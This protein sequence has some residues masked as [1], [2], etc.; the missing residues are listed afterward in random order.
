LA[1]YREKIKKRERYPGT[2]S[3]PL[4]AGRIQGFALCPAT[5]NCLSGFPAKFNP[6]PGTV[7]YN[8][9]VKHGLKPIDKLEDWI[10]IDTGESDMFFPW[11]TKESNNYINM[12]QITSYF[13]DN[14]IIREIPPTTFFNRILRFI[15][16]VYRPMALFRLKYDITSFN[17]EY[18]IYRL[19]RRLARKEM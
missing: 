14:K 6:L 4:G 19:F 11:Y 15:A 13:I 2:R 1:G 8:E 5:E 7:L 3:V 10:A 18:L 12:F 17:I 9:A 16:V